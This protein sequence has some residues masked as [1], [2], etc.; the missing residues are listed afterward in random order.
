[1]NRGD[2]VRV[3]HLTDVRVDG[4]SLG[5]KPPKGKV[6][7]LCLLGTEDKNPTEDSVALDP[8]QALREMGWTLAQQQAEA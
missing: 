4:V 8:E 6:Y 7:V 2:V 5:W 1:M 3:T